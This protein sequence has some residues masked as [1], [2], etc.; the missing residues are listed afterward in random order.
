MFSNVL[1]NLTIFYNVLQNLT[2]FYNI[3]QYFK[4][5]YNILQYFTNSIKNTIKIKKIKKRPLR[6]NI[7]LNNFILQCFTRECLYARKFSWNFL[8]W[9]WQLKE[10]L[11][12]ENYVTMYKVHINFKLQELGNWIRSF[13]KILKIESQNYKLHGGESFIN[14]EW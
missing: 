11:R 7:F 1:Q 6:I 12:Y 4:M 2:I 14:N 13:H 8:K 3:L 10:M 9:L 5:F